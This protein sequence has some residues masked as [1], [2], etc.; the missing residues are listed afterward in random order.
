MPDDAELLIRYGE[1]HSQE[2]FAEFVERNLGLVYHAALRRTNNDLHLAEDVVQQVFLSVALNAAKVARHAVPAGWLYTATRNA[3]ANLMR[4]ERRRRARELK[5][6]TMQDSRSETGTIP[7]WER[8][9]PELDGL[10]DKLDRKD[11]DAVILRCMQNRPFAEIGAVLRISEEAARKR[12]AR[13]LERLR[14]LLASR[15]ITSTAAALAA[16]LEGQA[17]LAAPVGLAARVSGLALT[18]GGPATGA[19][20]A[21]FMNSTT[22]VSLA[23]AIAIA[24]VAGGSLYVQHG[25]VVRLRTEVS[26]LHLALGGHSGQSDIVSS[27]ATNA[28]DA[29]AARLRAG[30]AGSKQGAPSR[31]HRG[32]R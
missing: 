13:S 10:M 3:A 19:T 5:A 14:G 31:R 30:E 25:Y 16:F 9:R 18:A 2:A 26:S 23:V 29:S 6:M 12:V 27:G 32:R 1:S 24:V 21:I 22:K 15:G 7:D 28:M 4:S 17:G 20:A 8:L 11:R